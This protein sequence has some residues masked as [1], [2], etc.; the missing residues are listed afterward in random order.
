MYLPENNFPSYTLVGTKNKSATMLVNA[1]YSIDT[2][3]TNRG[4]HVVMHNILSK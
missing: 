4:T 3:G 2:F 1:F